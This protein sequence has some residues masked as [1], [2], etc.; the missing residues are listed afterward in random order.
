M[1]IDPEHTRSNPAVIHPTADRAGLQVIHVSNRCAVRS[2]NSDC[3]RIMPIAGFAL[4]L[5]PVA[6]K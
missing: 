1:D 4:K 3:I 2:C 6:R 5:E